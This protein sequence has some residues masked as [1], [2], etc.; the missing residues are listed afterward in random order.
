MFVRKI[1]PYLLFT[2]CG[3]WAA[4]AAANIC[5]GVAIQAAR[6]HQVPENILLA[7]TRTETGRKKNGVFA[8]WPWTINDRGKGYWFNS[9][10]EMLQFAKNLRRQGVSSFDLGCFQLNYRWHSDGFASIED[11]VDPDKNAKYA[12]MF[13]RRL[14]DEFNDWTSAAGAY[15]SRTP[16]YFNSYKARFSQILSNL[17]D[18]NV[19]T[20]TVATNAYPLLKGSQDARRAGSLV[21]LQNFAKPLIIGLN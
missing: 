18:K 21:P 3:L 8:P 4:A 11:M 1:L 2:L 13:I 9:Q 17:P 7:L 10:N 16:K 14:Y 5:D 20:T 15:H 19:V 12:A 6:H